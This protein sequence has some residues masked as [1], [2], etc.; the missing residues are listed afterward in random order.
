MDLYA[1]SRLVELPSGVRVSVRRPSLIT[2]VAQGA[3]PQELTALIVKMIDQEPVETMIQNPEMF[4][5]MFSLIDR[6]IPFILVDP[7]IE[8]VTEVRQDEDGTLH[9]K[10]R[11][12]D[13]GDADKQFIFL[14]GQRL[15]AGKSIEV[16]RVAKPGE[17]GAT[18]PTDEEVQ[19]RDLGEFRPGATGADPGH[20]GESVQSAPVAAGGPIP[21]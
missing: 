20:P 6:L 2:L 10:I 16:T 9:G 15:L 3:F 1:G 5:S 4:R 13:L 14:Y 19:V 7:K 21:A 17:A 8:N 12:D 18:I 11:V